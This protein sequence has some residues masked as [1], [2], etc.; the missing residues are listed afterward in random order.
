M[1][2]R[3]SHTDRSALIGI[4]YREIIF[5][6][7]YNISPFQIFNIETRVLDE[8]FT[9]GLPFY[10]SGCS[11]QPLNDKSKSHYSPVHLIHY[12]RPNRRLDH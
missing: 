7:G 4:L 1:F 2:D 8:K 11:R 5:Q 12:D 10:G 9:L 6:P 3:L